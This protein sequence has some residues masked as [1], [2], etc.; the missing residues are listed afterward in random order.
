MHTNT[1]CIKIALRFRSM[2]VRKEVTYWDVCERISSMRGRNVI[3]DEQH[4]LMFDLLNLP[5]FL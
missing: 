2:I 1:Y 5:R 4:A 3:T